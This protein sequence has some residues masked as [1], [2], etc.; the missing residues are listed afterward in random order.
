MNLNNKLKLLPRKTGVYKFLNRKREILYIGKATNLYTRVNSYFSSLH[1]DRPRIAKMIDLISNVEYVE[2]N[3]EVESLILESALIKKYKPKYNSDQKDDKS[4]AWIYINI[5]DRYPTLRIVRNVTQ[6]LN[7]N[8]L[9]FGPYPKGK[10][11]KQIFTYVRKIFPFCTAKDP[12]KPCFH[13]RIGLCPGPRATKKE[14]MGNIEGI[15]QLL[16]GKNRNIIRNMEKEMNFFSNI[17]EYEK[18]AVIRDRIN[19][20]N[21]LGTKVTYNYFKSETEYIDSQKHKAL[22]SCM[23]LSKELNKQPLNRIECYDISNLSGSH[24]YGSMSVLTN[25]ELRKSDYRI[26]KIESNG[27]Q[28]DPLML[29]TVLKRRI[30]HISKNTDESLSKTPDLILIDGGT[31]QISQLL[32]IIPNSI[33]LIG[34]SKG[35]RYK[36]KGNSL[37][38]EFWMRR[39]NT[40]VQIQ[41]KNPQLLITLRDEAHRFALLFNRR[42]RLKTYKKSAL[43]NIVGVGPVTRKKLMLKYKNIDD[44]KNSTYEE[45]NRIIRNSKLT[46]EILRALNH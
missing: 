2:T 7:R 18:A 19:D 15:I 39:A 5:K 21:Y 31:S 11:V 16:K 20:L 36:R 42:S 29:K 44:I 28:N 38:D 43:D 46:T 22:I 30:G 4:Y 24:T 32:N 3:N 41:L 12:S 23:K 14:Y 6:E 25:G 17:Q 9:L 37:K 26:F 34:I 27:K 8:G 33:L 13:S 1:N 35:R 40:V 45:L 10:A